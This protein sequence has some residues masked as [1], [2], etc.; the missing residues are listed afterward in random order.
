MKTA[1][2]SKLYA[3]LEPAERFRALV[4]AMARDDFEERFRLED[5]TPRKT[6]TMA[7]WDAE[8]LRDRALGMAHAFLTGWHCHFWR[9]IVAAMSRGWRGP[10]GKRLKRS[11]GRDFAEAV[12]LS[13]LRAA[14]ERVC[15]RLGI[16]ETDFRAAYL[17]ELA[18]DFSAVGPILDAMKPFDPPEA[19]AAEARWFGIFKNAWKGTVFEPAFPDGTRFLRREDLPRLRDAE[20]RGESIESVMGG[21][22]VPDPDGSRPVAPSGTE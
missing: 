4:S 9:W 12:E 22:A 19:R 3:T 15:E 13:G 11:D 7:D 18:N 21:P 8:V 1:L 14:L 10:K 16:A 5:S 17:S 6:Y 20:R 2:P